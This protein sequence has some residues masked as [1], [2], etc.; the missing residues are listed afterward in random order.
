[1]TGYASIML[2]CISKQLSE[3]RVGQVRD[4]HADMMLY[5]RE[6]ICG[7]LFGSEFAANNLEIADAV[8]VVFGD[9]RAEVLYLPIWRRL[10]F[11]R[12]IRWNRAVKRLN[13][14]IETII[15]RGGAAPKLVK[16]F[17]VL[18]LVPM[19]PMAIPCQ[20]NSCMMKF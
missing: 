13:H 20:T 1:M 16:I 15:G 19:T 17:S 6:T 5:T 10:P 7:V 2:K 11:A 4:I 3:W 18:F 12:S 9:L 8:S 14:S